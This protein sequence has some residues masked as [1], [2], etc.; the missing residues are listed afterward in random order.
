MIVAEFSFTSGVIMA[1]TNSLSSLQIQLE[2]AN[3]SLIQP[4]FPPVVRTDEQKYV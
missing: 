1:K 4:T 2:N 3:L